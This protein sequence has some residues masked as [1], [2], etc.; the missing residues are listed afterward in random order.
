MVVEG[1]MLVAIS[2][3]GNKV[4]WRL[5]TE[6][7]VGILWQAELWARSECLDV[8]EP[9]TW[10]GMETPPVPS[11]DLGSC[12]APGPLVIKENCDWH[13]AHTL[14]Y[15]CQ[16]MPSGPRIWGSNSSRMHE[17]KGWGI[18]GKENSSGRDR[19]HL[20]DSETKSEK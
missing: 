11:G 2:Y 13:L 1:K 17:N 19:R 7:L 10:S 12:H 9:R 16:E 18:R 20:R 3:D 4:G 14:L 15:Y 8:L 6:N 5:R